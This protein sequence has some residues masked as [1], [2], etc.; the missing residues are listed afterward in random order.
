MADIAGTYGTQQR[1]T[2][3]MTQRIRIAMA[4]EALIMRDIDPT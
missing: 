3:R 4:V 1:I 2:N